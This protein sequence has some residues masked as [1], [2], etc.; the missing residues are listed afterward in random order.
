M[1]ALKSGTIGSQLALRQREKRVLEQAFQTATGLLA[2]DTA[3]YNEQ[4][5]KRIQGS[6]D[7]ETFRTGLF[8]A[9]NL[10]AEPEERWT[11]FIEA[12]EVYKQHLVSE[13]AHDEERCLYCRQALDPAAR[14]LV[15]RY[16]A[17]LE[18]KISSDLRSINQELRTLSET[19]RDLARSDVDSFIEE[20]KDDEE[21]PT[22]F[23]TLQLISRSQKIS[24]ASSRSRGMERRPSDVAHRSHGGTLLGDRGDDQVG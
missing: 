5:A 12:G 23:E 1:S 17:Y 15:S 2:F 6:A 7:L 11:A 24:T 19:V 8:E 20:H 9:A 10:P 18:D 4:L 16:S 21:K 3:R 13:A 14:D 22:Q